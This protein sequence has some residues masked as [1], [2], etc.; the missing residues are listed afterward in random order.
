MVANHPFGIGDGIAVLAMAEQLGRPFRVMI[1]SDLLKIRE[2]QPYALPVDFSESKAALRN[3][4][5]VRHEAVRLLKDGTVIVVFPAG[6]VATAPKGF[7]KAEDLPWKL[8]PARLVQEARATVI[9]VH[10]S[11]QNTWAFHAVSRFSMTLRIAML[12]REFTRL[13]GRMIRVRSGKPI[14]WPELEAFGGRQD[15]TGHLRRTVFALEA[16]NSVA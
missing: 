3:N 7:G 10:F 16:E 13:Q 1:N 4:L 8:F 5:A 14:S 6:G 2:M 11:G 15:L 9:P 12:I